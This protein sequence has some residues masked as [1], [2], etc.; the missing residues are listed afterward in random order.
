MGWSGKGILDGDEP[1]DA[2]S[3]IAD[4]CGC[5]K[6]YE[7]SSDD[8]LTKE[9]LEKHQAAIL[10]KFKKKKVSI[11]YVQTFAAYMVCA[12]AS[13]NE[14]PIEDCIK[15]LKMDEWA[16]Q[17]IER[18]YHIDYLINI[19]E[20][21][22]NEPTS[23]YDKN[24]DYDYRVGKTSKYA[25]YILDIFKKSDFFKNE[26]NISASI[27]IMGGTQYG[28]VVLFKDDDTLNLSDY[29]KNSLSEVFELKIVYVSSD[30]FILKP[31]PNV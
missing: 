17:D 26:I 27:C 16:K 3:F 13:F 1:M 30:D 15:N 31:N 20:N 12:G 18:K 14:F 10:A 22:N 2:A 19:L 23:Y 28:I 5:P 8:F 29:F 9:N 24:L 6:N 25:T 7:G 11:I 4:I 21:Y